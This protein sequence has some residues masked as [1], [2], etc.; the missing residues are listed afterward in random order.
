M[1]K[2]LVLNN[3]SVRRFRQN[4]A[5]SMDVLRELIEL[6]R[7]CP[8]AANRQPLKYVLCNDPPMN[9]GVFEHLAWAGYLKDWPGPQEGERPAAYIIICGD[10]NITPKFGCD[11][12]IAAQ[13][14]MLGAVEKGLSGCMIGS[15]KKEAL[16]KLLNLNDELEILLI[17][18]L[19]VARE[20][21]VIE[22]LP[23]T[24]SIEY[25]RD[26]QE[27]HHVPKRALNDLIVR[28]YEAANEG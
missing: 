13:T 1:L 7:L 2:E 28:C 24:K 25:W 8:S 15:I 19:G 27:V 10:R 17:L 20:K 22:S 6:A 18:A 23:D 4:Q 11:H 5:V 9:A 12:G 3:R 21:V 14:I 26:E 16:S